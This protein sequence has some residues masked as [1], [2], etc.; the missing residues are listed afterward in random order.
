MNK[1]HFCDVYIA[2]IP[3]GDV[4]YKSLYPES[5]EREVL[6]IKNERVKREKYFVWRLFEHALKNSL[7]ISIN[8]LKIEKNENGKWVADG[9]NFSLSHSGEA[10]AVALSSGA[11]GIDIEPIFA[12]KNENIAKRILTEGELCEFCSLPEDQGREYLIRKWTAKEAAFKASDEPTFRP[13]SIE[14]SELDVRWG[15]TLIEGERYVFALFDE[16]ACE[17]T[18][19]YDC[20]V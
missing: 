2:P 18:V 17:P 20:C 3:S 19:F 13:E 12:V 15:E 4:E 8:Y 9:I 16:G 11:V 14:V 10:V 5:R 6:Q 7:D 1:K